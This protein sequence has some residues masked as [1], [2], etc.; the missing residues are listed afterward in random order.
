M[1]LCD[2]SSPKLPFISSKI[3]ALIFRSCSGEG[4]VMQ[5]PVHHFADCFSIWLV[6]AADCWLVSFFDNAV[7]DI[8]LCRTNG[9]SPPSL[10]DKI[11]FIKIVLLFDP[12]GIEKAA[13]LSP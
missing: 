11:L 12:G 2:L 5:M 6:R 3:C 7:A 1:H 10:S 4:M 13:L 8:F 9:T